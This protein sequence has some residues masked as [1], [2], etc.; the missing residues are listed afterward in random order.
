MKWEHIEGSDE[1]TFGDS[2]R[3]CAKIEW[4]EPEKKFIWFSFV[5]NN[6]LSYGSAKRLE[7]VQ[8]EAEESL[9]GFYEEIGSHV[10]SEEKD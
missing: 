5:N 6:I 3:F 8:R 2:K 1:W 9:L 7:A 10:L 4:L